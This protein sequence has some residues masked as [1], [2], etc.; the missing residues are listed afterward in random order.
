MFKKLYYNNNIIF[1]CTRYSMDFFF[2]FPFCKR[3]IIV[4]VYQTI[5][6]F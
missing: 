2:F 4:I 6:A 5:V 1:S 3:N